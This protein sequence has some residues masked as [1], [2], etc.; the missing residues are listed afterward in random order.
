MVVQANLTEALVVV[1]ATLMEAL[2]VH[3]IQAILLVAQAILMDSEA[4]LVEAQQVRGLSKLETW[5]VHWFHQPCAKGWNKLRQ[6]R[7]EAET[8]FCEAKIDKVK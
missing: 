1:Q 3:A 8:Q 4:Q 5:V 2:V 6:R 7:C